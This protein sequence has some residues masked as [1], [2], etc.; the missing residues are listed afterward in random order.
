MNHLLKIS[1]IQKFKDT[2]DSGYI[3]KN[4]LCKACFEHDMAYGDFEDVARRTQ[5][6]KVLRNKA[7]NIV[8]K[9]KIWWISKRY[10]FYSL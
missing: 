7:F 1:R 6:D 4:E 9:L 8:K 5:S 2:G 3:Y 10:C